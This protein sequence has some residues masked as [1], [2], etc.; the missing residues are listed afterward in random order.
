MSSIKLNTVEFKEMVSKAVKG[1]SDNNN[2]YLTQL[3]AIDLTDNV[4]TLITTDT[5]NYLYVRK[6]KVPGDDFYAVVPVDRFSRLISKIT[7]D[8]IKLETSIS[9]SGADKLVVKGNGSYVIEL[10]HDIDGE[11]VEFPDPVGDIDLDS[12]EWHKNDINLSTIHLMLATA[13]PALANS[14]DSTNPYTGYY[15]GEKIVATDTFKICGIDVDVLD[16]PSLLS[17]EMVDLLD[18]MRDEN[19]KIAYNDDH[20]VF[21][22]SDCVVY[23]T[24]KEGQ[25][26]QEFDPEDE[27]AATKYQVGAIS[28]LLDEPF[29]SSCS[30]DKTALLQMLDRISLFVGVND[31]N[32]VCLTFTKDGLNVSSKQNSGDEIIPYIESTDFSDFTCSTD[33]NM[34]ISQVKASRSPSIKIYYGK[35]R[36]IKFS[37]DP[38]TQIVALEGDDDEEEE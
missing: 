24:K 38:I 27:D 30:V 34:L 37:D 9:D 22:S 32:G 6:N 33:I 26:A 13:K 4:F 15:V 19:I 3:M 29:P 36:T 20:V 12:D 2:L 16:E 28:G 21:T 10:P 11:L 17:R 5:N 8:E 35:D 14:K 25:I 31:K 7:C 1:A 23:G 18:V